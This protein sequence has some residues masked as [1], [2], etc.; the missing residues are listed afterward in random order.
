MSEPM[1]VAN[2][3]DLLSS[4]QPDLYRSNAYRLLGLSV[5][6]TTRQ[7]DQRSGLIKVGMAVDSDSP[8]STLYGPPTPEE[9]E[10]AAKH[11]HDPVNQFFHWLFWLWTAEEKGGA[12][13]PDDIVALH[14]SAILSHAKALA[15]EETARATKDKSALGQEEALWGECLGCWEQVVFRE[16]F[17]TRLSERAESLDD[18]RLTKHLIEGTEII[19][20]AALLALNGRQAVRASED[21]DRARAEMHVRLLRSHFQSWDQERAAEEAVARVRDSLHQMLEE[22]GSDCSDN[23]AKLAGACAD[24]L[25]R[26]EKPLLT[27]DLV[28]PVGYPAIEMHHD[29]VALKVL[30]MQIAYAKATDDWRRSLDLLQQAAAVARGD[31][32]RS[33]LAENTTIVQRNLESSTCWYC[34]KAPAEEDSSVPV[35]LYRVVERTSASND[36]NVRWGEFDLKIPRTGTWSTPAQV[37]VRWEKL[38]LRIPRCRRCKAVL[39]GPARGIMVMC[40]ISWVGIGPI[41]VFHFLPRWGIHVSSAVDLALLF[42]PCIA[43]GGLYSW[44]PGMLGTNDRNLTD[45]PRIKELQ[46]EGWQIGEKPPG[47]S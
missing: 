2:W 17:L 6:A 26:A 20:P 28:L 29:E 40:A 41:L 9:A 4:L 25:S 12:A 5:E 35:S 44:I 39:E 22:A 19:L 33:R 11:L 24:L 34:G 42:V 1:R 27:L 15:S 36:V 10:A 14:D 46:A 18:P 3:P 32:A 43:L 21:G 8:L 7:I 16:D 45:Y 13:G 38:D 31:Q 30:E 47:V 37:N 23:P